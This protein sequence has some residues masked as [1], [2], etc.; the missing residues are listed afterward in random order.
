[1]TTD[2]QPGQHPPMFDLTPEQLRDALAEVHRQAVTDVGTAA[3]AAGLAR[4]ALDRAVNSARAAGA[5][6][7]EIGRAAGL[8]RQAARQRWSR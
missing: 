2:P 6:W 7:T 1:M 3:E 8:T 5:S 4:T